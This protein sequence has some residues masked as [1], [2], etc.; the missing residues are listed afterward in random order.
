MTAITQTPG[1]KYRNSKGVAQ[2]KNADIQALTTQVTDAQYTV[3][4]L[5]N[6]VT[7][8]TSKQAYFANLLTIASSRQASALL[9]YNQAKTLLS[10]IKETQNYVTV[11]AKQVG[12]EQDSESLSG[13]LN[14]T[15]NY[16]ARVIDKLIF[17]ADI[18][19]K[20]QDFVDRRKAVNQVIPDDLVTYL[21]NAVT[22]SNN[23]VSLTLTALQSC[24]ASITPVQET[25]EISTLQSAQMA[26]L[27]TQTQSLKDSLATSYQAS[28][29]SY[30]SA[31]SASNMANQQLEDAQAQLAEAKANL[32]SLNAGLEA[33][34]AAAFAA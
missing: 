22:E 10:D 27:Y 31:L 7:S 9:H 15:A 17:S 16:M 4:E 1:P 26:S 2:N 23:A 3:N 24:Y 20:L 29:T 21:N 30:Q 14:E 8:L 11:V 34:K 12:S 33:A 19:E 6:V 25:E 13:K 28:E 5:T 18:I 32:A